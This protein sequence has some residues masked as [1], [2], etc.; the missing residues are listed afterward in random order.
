M[1][2]YLHVPYSDKEEAKAL[3]AKWNRDVECWYVPSG[4][5]FVPFL[6]WV[7]SF[8]EETQLVGPVYIRISDTVCWKCKETTEVFCL[9]AKAIIDWGIDAVGTPYPIIHDEMIFYNIMNLISIDNTI[10][11]VIYKTYSQYRPDFLPKQGKQK[12]VNHCQC[13]DAQ[14]QDYFLHMKEDGPFFYLKPNAG[15]Q[16]I[17]EEGRFIFDGGY[18]W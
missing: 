16:R 13:C 7:I 5:S 11:G 18:I 1:R 12:W 4:V 15:D 9:A 6:K 17:S 10:A 2:K 3:G 14:L 8:P